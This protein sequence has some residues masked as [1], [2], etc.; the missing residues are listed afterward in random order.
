MLDSYLRRRAGTYSRA[1]NVGV[2]DIG[3][4]Y[5]LICHNQNGTIWLWNYCRRK[6]YKGLVL[7]KQEM[8]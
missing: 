2:P 1:G 8:L 4:H 6:P 3:P 5:T 7:Y